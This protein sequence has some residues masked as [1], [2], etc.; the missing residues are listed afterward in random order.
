GAIPMPHRICPG[1]ITPKYDDSGWVRSRSRSPS[2]ENEGPSVMNHLDPNRSDRRP[3]IGAISRIINGNGNNLTPAPTGE[4]PWTS[5]KYSV[6]KNTVPK[7][8]KNT[9][10]ATKLAAANVRIRK[11]DRGNIGDSLRASMMKNAAS[12]IAASANEPRIIPSVQP[13]LLPSIRPYTRNSSPS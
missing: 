4:Y 7:S 3:A 10:A 1:K 9:A 5:W 8:A 2:A 12:T 6:M 11:N 13:R